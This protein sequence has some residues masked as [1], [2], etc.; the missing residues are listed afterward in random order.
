MS[1]SLKELLS[2]YT[3]PA[4]GELVVDEGGGV[5]RCQACANRCQIPE[6]KTGI[7]RVRFNRGGRLWVPAGYVAGL[8]ID[9]IEKKPFF[10]VLPGSDALSFGMLGCNF[11]CS[12]CQNWVSSQALREDRA[13]AL[14]DQVSAEQM[15]DLAVKRRVPIMVSTY[16]EPLITADWAVE[17]FKEARKH[18]ILCGFVS[19]GHA[20]PEVLEFLRPHMDLYKVD[21]KCYNP[22]NYRQL[23]GKLDAVLDSIGLL[24]QMGFWVEVVTLVVPTFNDSDEELTAIAKFIADVS[25]DIPWHT[26]AF[27]PDYKM[28]GP[29]RTPVE[30]LSRAY[31]IGKASG[32][33]F[34]YSGNLPGYVEDRENTFC[35]GCNA[36][37]VRRCGFSVS[38]NRIA[39]GK[40]PDCATQI[41]GVWG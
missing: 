17:I 9:P 27:H 34:V 30:T 41:A 11:H 25:P 6:G 8:N 31:D 23:G 35:P 3:M 2:D 12:F 1:K 13:M 32:L 29:P 40:C 10:H 33:K 14:P 15:L 22:E 24:K 26:T 37:L 38:E 36:L 21:L 7:C 39:E 18:G 16:N 4:A 5:L 19:N 28:T 20:T